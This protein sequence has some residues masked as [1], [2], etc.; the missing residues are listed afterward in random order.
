M[1]KVIM[2]IN[3]KFELFW[4]LEDLKLFLRHFTYQVPLLLRLLKGPR[5]N[6]T[7]YKQVSCSKKC[8]SVGKFGILSVVCDLWL[9]TCL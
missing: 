4:T 1:I 9:L 5:P 6:W 3:L 2:T 7:I 8:L